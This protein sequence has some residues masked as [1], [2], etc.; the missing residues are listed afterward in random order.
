MADFAPPL[1]N[2]TY[3]K[4]NPNSNFSYHSFKGSA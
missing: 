4:T 1:S 2:Q 3:P